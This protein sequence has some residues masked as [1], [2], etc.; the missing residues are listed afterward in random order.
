MKGGGKKKN[1]LKKAITQT[2]VTAK[3]NRP[4]PKCK[5]P[6]VMAHL[7]AATAILF[8]PHLGLKSILADEQA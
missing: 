1:Y 6:Q 3:T 5:R 2:R 7:K 8:T 4:L